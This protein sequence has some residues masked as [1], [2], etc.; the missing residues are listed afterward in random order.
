MVKPIYEFLLWDNCNNNCKFCFQRKK[1][2]LLQKQQQ[3]EVLLK[4]LQFLDSEKYQRGSHVLV[5]GGEI[6][7]DVSR[8]LMLV[9]FFKGLAKKMQDKAIDL[10]YLNTNLLY[11][12]SCVEM[13]CQCLSEIDIVDILQRVKFTTSYD[14]DGRFKT[15]EHEK[16]FLENIKFLKQVMPQLNIVVNMIL[17]KRL[18]QSINQKHFNAFTFMQQ[19][20]TKI[21]FIPYIVLDQSLQA[22]RNQVFEA[23]MQMHRENPT[24]MQQWVNNQDLKQPRKMFYLEDDAFK[25]CECKVASCGHS[26][27]FKLYSQNGSCFVCDLKKLFDGVM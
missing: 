11:S 5:V 9:H 19:T 14:L 22:E 6:F 23:L 24:Y 4:I 18:C 3:Q 2:R 25:S 10:L 16:L 27:N 26:E 17:T 21:N 15:K 13:L 7:D 12:A 1:P 20:G 8:R